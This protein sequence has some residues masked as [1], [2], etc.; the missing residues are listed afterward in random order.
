MSSNTLQQRKHEQTA[1]GALI[2]AGVAWNSLTEFG[3]CHSPFCGLDSQHEAKTTAQ[4]L[5]LGR[6]SGSLS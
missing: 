2:M 5:V 1:P 4:A 3:G 6:H